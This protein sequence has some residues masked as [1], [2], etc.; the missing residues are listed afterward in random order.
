MAVAAVASL[1]TAFYAMSEQFY[2]ACD[3]TRSGNTLT[4]N[5]A[6]VVMTRY[7]GEYT[8]NR[9]AGCFF[10]GNSSNYPSSLWNVTLND[11]RHPSP[12]TITYSIGSPSYS[13]SDSSLLIGVYV[14]STGASYDWTNFQG[15][16][17]LSLSVALPAPADYTYTNNWYLTSRTNTSL[18]YYWSTSDSCSQIRYG[19]STSNY[20]QISVNSSSGT[21]TFNNLA[22]KAFHYINPSFFPFCYII[23]LLFNTRCKS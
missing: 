23:K 15:N 17:P 4:L 20:N 9:I 13:T 10:I 5:N 14:A 8:T 3:V 16:S 19:T 12:A 18:T 6:R 21:V 22:I 7:S 11:N 2:A 1:H